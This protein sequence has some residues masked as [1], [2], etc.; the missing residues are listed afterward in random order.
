MEIKGSLPSSQKPATGSNGSPNLI[1]SLQY[2][3][4][5]AMNCSPS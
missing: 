5:N 1:Y 4:T 2:K 3:L